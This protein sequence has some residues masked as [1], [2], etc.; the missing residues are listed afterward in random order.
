[1]VGMEHWS[2]YLTPLSFSQK[3]SDELSFKE[4]DSMVVLSKKKES[5]HWWNVEHSDGRKGCI[6]SIYVK[7][8]SITVQL[9]PRE[10]Q[11]TA[12]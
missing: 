10:G 6:P 9:G 2:S 12:M 5:D 7:A 1:M 4:G 3:K 11:Y 8:V